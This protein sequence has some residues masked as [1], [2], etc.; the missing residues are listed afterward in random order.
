M[1]TYQIST[2][3]IAHDGELIGTGYSGFGAGKNNIADI[4]TEGVGP[5]PPGD[6][7]IGPLSDGHPRLGPEVMALIPHQST[8][9]FGRSGFFWHGDSISHPGGA[10]HGCICSGPFIRRKVDASTDKLLRAIE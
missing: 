1:W 4:A 2:G 7:D 5:I 6:Y 9:T 8:E 3:A 10:S